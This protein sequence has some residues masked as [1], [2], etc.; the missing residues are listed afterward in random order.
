MTLE[1]NRA[2]GRFC[3][4][5]TYFYKNGK[6]RTVSILSD[7]GMIARTTSWYRNGKKMASGNYLHQQR[8]SLWEFFS[9]YDEA[10]VSEEFYVDGKKEG[11]EK[12]F[13]PG[14]GVAEV[15]TWNAG[16]REGPWKQFYDD[17]TPKLVG[18]YVNDEREGPVTTYFVTGKVLASGQYKNGHQHG[19]WIY[20]DDKGNITL[21]EFFNEGI[22]V[23]K[24]DFREG[25]GSR[26]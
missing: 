7:S 5:L 3:T 16:I 8:D 14:K 6:V 19:D 15:I 13:Y 12:I 2:S 4:G 18:A 22:L 21:K 25:E 24:E 26:Q 23:K 10:L 11:E 20:Y 1:E 17:G 9:E